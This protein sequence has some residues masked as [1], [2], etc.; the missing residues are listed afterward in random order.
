[1]MPKVSFTVAAPAGLMLG[2]HR[3]GDRPARCLEAV[4]VR[5][6]PQWAVTGPGAG[7]N[8]KDAGE[9]TNQFSKPDENDVLNSHLEPCAYDIIYSIIS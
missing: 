7:R 2:P 3:D 9:A 5:S 8:M 6:R 1:M 4:P